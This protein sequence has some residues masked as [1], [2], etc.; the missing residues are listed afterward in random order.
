[1]ELPDKPADP[2]EV[3]LSE[4]DD[5]PPQKKTETRE[6]LTVDVEITF[7]THVGWDGVLVMLFSLGIAGL[8]VYIVYLYTKK[9]Q[10][11][12]RPGVWVFMVFAVLY[13]LVPLRYLFAWKKIAIS[14]SK[15]KSNKRNH[16]FVRK[17]LH[18]RNMFN[19][20]G[21]LFLWKF[22]LFEFI[23]SI[24]QLVNLATVYLCTLPVE[25]TTSMCILLSTDA[26]YRAYQ[27]RQ[28]NTIARRDN[29]IKIDMCIDFFCVAL[30]I[31]AL[32]FAYHIPISI[33]E[34]IQIT[35]WPT[36]CLFSKLRSI[37]REIIRVRTDNA[38]L[39]EQTRISKEK[40]SNR[41][42]LFRLSSSV[43]SSKQQQERMP[44]IV[45]TGFSIYNIV[46]GLF[47][48]T[49]GIAHLVMQPTGCGLT[50]WSKECVNK[51]PFCKSLFT[52][53]CNCASLRIENNK[54]LVMLPNSLVDDM[55]G[56]RKVFIRNCNLTKLP[57]RMEQLTEMVDF[58]ISF[59][60]L[61]VFMVDVGKWEKLENLYLMYN[62]IS[63]YNEDVLWTHPQLVGLA[64]ASNNIK[65]PATRIYLPSL[66][67]LHLGENNLTITKPFD[68]KML[69]N[70]ID[71]Y[72]NGNNLESFPSDSLKDNIVSLG[73]A[74]CN[75]K[76][77]PSYL[78][79]FKYLRYLDVRDNEIENVDDD[80]KTLLR[81]NNG[82][83]S[84][85]SGN[86]VCVKDSSLDCEP[87][88]SK[89]CWSRKVR[90]ND[91]CDVSCKSKECDYD[92]GD[93]KFHI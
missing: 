13:T 15:N 24:N 23:E 73:I 51:I 27:L 47:F 7:W 31:C 18:F 19:T 40:G 11:W 38:I 71:L 45:S 17:F 29:Q 6:Q 10:A 67:F 54:S 39:L 32:W 8:F 93:C 55:T 25:A 63:N 46:Y 4:V 44:K 34:M 42:M 82:V 53:T 72:L 30:P 87:L 64:L 14:Y 77:L 88:C 52:P 70:I 81:T 33:A 69:P 37:L 1:M 89:T 85:F 22:Y 75:L 48:L 74:R 26:F 65:M 80:L 21:V 9:F 58:E 68:V 61:E 92:G 3:E 59:N 90:N 12:H 16:S 49:V 91:E 76:S 35:V 50:T 78:S 56:L 66:T 84:Y 41:K 57:P 20:N 43:K 86:A 2:K 28:P 83:E 79:T 60:R 62:N 5:K 36:L